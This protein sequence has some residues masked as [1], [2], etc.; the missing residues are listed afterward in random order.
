MAKVSGRHGKYVDICLHH[1]RGGDGGPAALAYIEGLADP[2]DQVAL[3][4]QHGKTLV[5][6]YGLE[7]QV[8]P[9][10]GA[11][12]TVSRQMQWHVGVLFADAVQRTLCLAGSLSCSAVLA[13]TLRTSAAC[14]AACSLSLVKHSCVHSGK[15]TKHETGRAAVC[16]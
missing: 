9:C 2:R 14:Q 8:R 10:L 7:M 16:R 13:S 6:T 15:T 3:L 11:W 1:M 5:S 4:Q 12:P